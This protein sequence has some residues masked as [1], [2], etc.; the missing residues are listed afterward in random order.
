MPRPIKDCNNF[1]I[2]RIVNQ[3]TA[4]IA[5]YHK[6]NKELKEKLMSADEAYNQ[7]KKILNEIN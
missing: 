1:E 6:Q 4:T 2:N 3:N 5:A 7:L